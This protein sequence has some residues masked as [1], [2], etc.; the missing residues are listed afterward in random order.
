MAVLLVVATLAW[1]VRGLRPAEIIEVTAEDGYLVDA[2]G[3]RIG[4]EHVG[5]RLRVSNV[6]EVRGLELELTR[7]A[8]LS[9]GGPLVLSLVAPALGLK[10]GDTICKRRGDGGDW[11]IPMRGRWT[12]AGTLRRDADG[13][14]LA[15]AS[16]ALG[17]CV[18]WGFA[19]WNV[20]ADSFTACTRMVR[21]DYCGDGRSFTIPGVR[22]AFERW[23][24]G[25]PLPTAVAAMR[26]SARFG[27]EALW[28]ADGARCVRTSRVAGGGDA[29]RHQC[30]DRA[31]D[32]EPLAKCLERVTA[33]TPMLANYCAAP[34]PDSKR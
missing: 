28:S 29:W 10:R 23:R 7:V 2:A 34:A 4:H 19:P 22:I 13:A 31:L 5:R 33:A 8:T 32:G 14:T 3:V 1:T 24:K 30:P 17:K 21:A 12:P 25:N 16:G 11:L 20:D 6:D 26:P 18:E 9:S 27:F 15:C